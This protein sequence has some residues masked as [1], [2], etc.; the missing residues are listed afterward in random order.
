MARLQKPCATC[1]KPCWGQHC[2]GC[3][4]A[5][6]PKCERRCV[7]CGAPFIAQNDRPSREP[8]KYCSLP[9]V[10]AALR[11][12]PTL[13]CEMCGAKFARKQSDVARKGGRFCS[14]PCADEAKRTGRKPSKSKPKQP[15]SEI[16]SLVCF[17]SCK[18]CGA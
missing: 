2:R 17:P 14:R 15:L 13:A 9:C 6:V 16:S 18:H 1:G 10:A 12:S 8:A 4:W 3:G 11:K 5:A 7:T